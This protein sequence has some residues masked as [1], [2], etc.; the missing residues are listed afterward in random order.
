MGPLCPINL[1]QVRES[2]VSLLRFQ[3]AP[4]LRLLTS[5]ILN[6]VQLHNEFNNLELTTSANS[7][8]ISPTGGNVLMVCTAPDLFV[9]FSTC[10][11]IGS[12]LESI[13]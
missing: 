12:I 7:C 3:I 9:G 11:Y 6:F 13:K 8:I 10:L 5:P 1:C 4:R 2:N